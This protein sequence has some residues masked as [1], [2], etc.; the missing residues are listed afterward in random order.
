[1]AYS[2]PKVRMLKNGRKQEQK[3]AK[4]TTRSTTVADDLLFLGLYDEAAPEM[5]SKVRNASSSPDL[6]YTIAASYTRGDLAHRGAVF[7]E[8]FWKLPADYQI[9]LIPPDALELLY[10]APFSDLLVRHSPQRNIDPRFLLS[11]M[12]QESRFRADARSSAAARGLMQFISTT[13]N[14]VAAELGRENFRQEDLYDPSTAI[15]FGSHYTGNL[16]KSFPNETEAVVASYNGG[17]DNMRRWLARA[18]SD[19][20]ERYVSE[21]MYAQTKDYV[22]RVMCNYRM[23]SVL[24]D[25]GL[26]RR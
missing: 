16:L 18:K 9:E 11:I 1:P 12:R 6:N 21:I 4:T 23:Y 5:E 22:E 8:S 13:A 3:R 25:E 24:Y 19:E 17:D 2:L 20:A 10:P 14:R 7:A 26:K 15:L